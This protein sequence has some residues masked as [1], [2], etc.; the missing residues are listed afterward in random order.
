MK[1]FFTL[2]LILFL[3]QT[4][5]AQNN[6]NNYQDVVTKFYEYFSDESSVNPSGG[7]ILDMGSASTGRISFNVKNVSISIK[8]LPERPGCADI[9]PPEFLI[10]FRCNNKSKCVVDP[11]MEEFGG[12][13]EGSIIYGIERGKE[14]YHFLLQLQTYFKNK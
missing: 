13:K 10:T 11:A 9:C 4:G 8:E 7:L 12:S 14:A 3:A 6:L 5:I 2:L 1:Q